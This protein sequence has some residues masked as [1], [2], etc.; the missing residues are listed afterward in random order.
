MSDYGAGGGAP[1]RGRPWWFWLLGGCGGCLVLVVAAS[2]VGGLFM[3]NLWDKTQVEPQT[4]A[5]VQKALGQVP[6]YP[7]SSFDQN[8]TTM[9]LK[10]MRLAEQVARK[11]KGSLVSALAS[12]NTPDPP[13]KVFAFYREKLTAL[14]WAEA[15][16]QNQSR[17]PQILFRKGKDVVLVQANPHKGGSMV[18]LMKGGMGLQT[19][20]IPTEPGKGM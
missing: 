4:E 7:G 12:Q 15:S 13:E 8:T 18:M 14:G 5:V 19:Q 9:T 3:K 17:Q 1:R 16:A 6:L 11:P 2:V 20:K 10:G